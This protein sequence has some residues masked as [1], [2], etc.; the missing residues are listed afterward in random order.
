MVAISYEHLDAD[1]A[2][3][4]ED[5]LL[6][7]YAAEYEGNGR[8][9]DSPG[10]FLR[11]L[12]VHL[13][14]DGYELV[15]ARADGE[16]VGFIYGSTLP[17]DTKWWERQLTPLPGEFTYETG[18]RTMAV[19]ELLV[20][21]DFRRRG[22]ASR[23]HAELF[24]GRSEQRGA[25]SVYPDNDVAKKAYESWGWRKVGR[26]QPFDDAPVFDSYVIEPLPR[27]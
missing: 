4:I 16:L 10:N 19:F 1:G 24:R 25:L 7:L 23:L 12:A 18:R 5:E 11:L 8:P 2:K 20:R 15:T 21:S 14:R 3:R 9:F 26:T 6:S 22:I 27:T 13:T 17:A